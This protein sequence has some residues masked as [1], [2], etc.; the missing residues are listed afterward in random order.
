MTYFKFKFNITLEPVDVRA[1]IDANSIK[2]KP[3]DAQCIEILE[4]AYRKTDEVGLSE[5]S[6]LWAIEKR[7]DFDDFCKEE[8][9]E[10]PRK[11]H[12]LQ[13]DS[14]TKEWVRDLY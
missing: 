6:I 3:T 11:P 5:S 10:E 7:L 8:L 4:E 12:L 2:W 13:Y 9:N 1:V 14:D